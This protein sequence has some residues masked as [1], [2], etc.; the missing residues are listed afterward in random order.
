MI[1]ASMVARSR[2]RYLAPIALAAVIAGTYV[3]VHKGLTTKNTPSHHT[4]TTRKRARGKYARAKYYV[5]QQGDSMTSIS[6]KTGIPLN[7]LEELNPSAD[8]N[9]L[10]TGRRLRLRR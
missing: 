8:P 9:S 5:I 4:S 1:G 7:V 10:Q 3:V 6:A 2:A